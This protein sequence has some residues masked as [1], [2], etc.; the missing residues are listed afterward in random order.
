MLKWISKVLVKY[1]KGRHALLV[2]DTFKGHLKE[3]VLAKLLEMNISHV[4]IPGGC[5]SKVQPLDV[6]LNKRI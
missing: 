3:E 5:T 2:F 1:T 4:V 6:S